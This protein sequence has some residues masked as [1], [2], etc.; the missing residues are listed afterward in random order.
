MV[1]LFAGMLV[2]LLPKQYRG[3]WAW[4]SS[5]D[6]TRATMLSGLAEVF[7]CLGLY[8]GRYLYFIQYRVGTLGEAA[9]KRGAEEALGAP[10]VQYGMG[11][12]SL[13][14]YVFSPLSVLLAYLAFEGT[15][16]VLAAAVTEETPGTL[17]LYLVA[18]A[19]EGIRRWRMERALGPRVMDEVYRFRGI[20]YDLGIASCRPKRDWDRLMTIEF[21]EEFY[22]V[23]EEK[24]GYPPR[25]YIYRLRQIPK[26]KVIRAIHH[27]HPDEVLS[28]KNK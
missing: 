18:W 11:F 19:F 17:P 2:S 8:I 7:V 23:F 22:E 27:Y 4:A 21:E 10:A 26:G 20:S 15:M 14:E 3:W 16:R 6:F 12:V 25:R 5:A 1:N 28:K 13:I 9:I 24:L